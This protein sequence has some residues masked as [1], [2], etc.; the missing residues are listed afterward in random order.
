MRKYF[1]GMIEEKNRPFW[2]EETVKIHN[3]YDIRKMELET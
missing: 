3:E 1:F 2:G